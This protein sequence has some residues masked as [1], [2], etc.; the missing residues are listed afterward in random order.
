VR[1]I[2]KYQ[3]PIP[4]EAPDGLG[5]PH[6]FINIAPTPIINREEVGRGTRDIVAKELLTYEF[7]CVCITQAS[8]PLRSQQQAY[9]IASAVETAIGKNRR[10]TVLPGLTDPLCF[11]LR[12][13]QV[14]FSLRTT[15]T[16]QAA[17][18]VL[19]RP[20]VFVDMTT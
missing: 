8:D 20:K 13:F 12:Y 10:L 14:P 1:Q 9:T 11:G 5:P 15:S 17:L 16:D 2:I 6:I 7:W 3:F 18:N 4:Q 19:V